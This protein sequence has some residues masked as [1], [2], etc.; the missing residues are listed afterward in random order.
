MASEVAVILTPFKGL[1]HDLGTP[2]T[3]FLL[4]D[5][6]AEAL[7]KA[8]RLLLENPSRRSR[9]ATQGHQWIR[10]TM[11]IEHSLDQYAALYHELAAGGR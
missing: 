8:L 9:L 7:S 1:S 10:Q 4:S 6:N 2:G 5:R 3:H 11:D